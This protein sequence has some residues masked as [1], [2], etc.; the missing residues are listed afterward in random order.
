VCA[1]FLMTV[2]MSLMTCAITVSDFQVMCDVQ[3]YKCVVKSCGESFQE[4]DSFLEHIRLHENQMSYRCHQCSKQFQ[5]LADLGM[6]QYT[7]SLYPNQGPKPGPKLVSV[8]TEL[9]SQYSVVLFL[10]KFNS[11]YISI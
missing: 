1:I 6:H 10:V 4:L 11:T 9:H 8:L 3:V 7:H 5:S 2:M